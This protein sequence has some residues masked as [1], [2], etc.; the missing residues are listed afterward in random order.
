MGYNQ[1]FIFNQPLNQNFKSQPLQVGRTGLIGL[2]YAIQ[3][4]F[5]GTTCIFTASI[6]VSSD[7]YGN[8]F[9]PM[10]F[11]TLAGSSQMMSQAGTFT[12]DINV[13]GYVWARLSIVDNSLGTNNGFLSARVNLNP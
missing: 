11:D 2:V 8:N 13:V 4:Q 6:E 1:Q 3:L 12:Y 10:T 7:P 9:V 5:T